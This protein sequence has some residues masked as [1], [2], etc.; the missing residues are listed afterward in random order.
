MSTNRRQ[1]GIHITEGNLRKLLTEHYYLSNGHD[2]NDD[3]VQE[4]VDDITIFLMKG[5]KKFSL[6]KRSIVM[7]NQTLAKKVMSKVTNDKSDILLLSNLIFQTRK[8]LKHR[9][10]KPIDVNS[11]DWAALKKLTPMV[12]DFCNDYQLEKRAGYLAYL[13]IGLKKITSFRG[14]INKLYDMSETINS[15]FEAEEL[16]TMDENKSLT[17]DIHDYY[18][19]LIVKN[20]GILEDYKDKP[21]KYLKFIEVAHLVK[22][23]KMDYKT[24]INAQFEGLAWTNNYPEPEQLVSD[25][26]RE[27]LNKY[28]YSS[29]GKAE[30]DKQLGKADKQLTNVL[31][32]IKNGKN[33]NE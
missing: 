6:E 28:L 2:V 3:Q 7:S 31:N 29:K 20:T 4:I 8:Q 10:I 18:I 24:F 32:K 25:K 17:R 19:S 22:G 1:A 5:A 15:Q 27:R 9:G 23:M 33:R 14:Y 16:I 13:N 11:S 12:N 26:Y 21:L 30:K